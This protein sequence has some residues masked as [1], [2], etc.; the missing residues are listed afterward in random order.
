MAAGNA[1]WGIEVGSGAVKAIKL[2]ATPT[3]AQ[4]AEY[5]LIQHPRVLSEPEIDPD[6]AK[7]V[8]LGRLVN[9]FD[10]SG[11]S[12][13]VSIP[14]HSSF[15]RFAKLPPVEPKKLGG[16][17]RYEA[18]QQI[19]FS[20]DEVE[21]DYQT[22]ASPD[23][24]EVEAGI[25]AVTRARIMQDLALLK[26]V[27]LTPDV[28]TLSPVAVY[29][30]LAWDL[31][32]T[33]QTPGT[34]ILDIGTTATDLIVA[35]AGR[36]WVRTFPMGGHEF[37]NALVEAFKLSYQKADKLK[38]E[39]EESKHAR[40]VFGALRPVFTDLAQD[41]Q[42]SIGY[43]QSLH[44]DAD[45]QRLIGLG[46]TFELPG[47]RKFLKQ[48]LGMNVYR[49]ERYKRIGIEGPRAAEFEPLALNLTTAYGLALQGLGLAT[50]EANLMPTGVIREALWK[51]KGKWFLTAA[52]L[53]LAAGGAM[54]IR[55]FLDS[56]AVN[57]VVPDISIDQA[58]RL[59]AD[60]SNEASQA[61]VT[62]PARG[63]FAAA[64][65]IGVLQGREIFPY[66]AA[67]VG[68]LVATGGSGPDRTFSLASMQ[69]EY[70]F[71][72][73][74]TFAEPTMPSRR[75]REE[76]EP[77][78]TDEEMQGGRGAI[79]A[80]PPADPR[81]R[82]GRDEGYAP[83]PGM[84]TGDGAPPP[85]GEPRILVTLELETT[86]PRDQ[87]L[88]QLPDTIGRWLRENAD[89][90][91]APYTVRPAQAG[92]DPWSIEMVGGPQPGAAPGRLPPREVAGSG[93]TGGRVAGGPRDPRGREGEDRG[94]ITTE[95]LIRQGILDP[96]N[97]VGGGGTA[98]A[99]EEAS[100][101]HAAGLSL[102]AIA[103]LAAPAEADPKPVTRVI[104]TFEAVLREHTKPGAPV[105]LD[106]GAA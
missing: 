81:S 40:H 32:F 90:P 61:G 35:E 99:R 1:C 95:D 33:E 60:F 26:E 41:V 103:P 105:R 100:R 47:L 84:G 101:Q 28:V 87:L 69:S 75:E 20:L 73:S 5:A 37:T 34:V 14:G 98:P 93:R 94:F 88:V 57:A 38:R 102:D 44:R 91:G 54:F 50:L 49:L 22:F 45:L 11:A 82:G 80:R 97:I 53:G 21:W 78:V 46:S 66:L 39:A 9:E 18:A 12:I 63:N 71:A 17:V 2:E 58:T 89:R 104:V 16:I 74:A 24:P 77:E 15:A 52:G 19:P 79:R 29:N 59:A 10:L 83:P 30:A 3:G 92:V 67:D 23:Q 56:A 86:A 65:V 13:A 6:D 96:G 4:V 42:R 7:R 68:E 25:F 106:G 76:I 64:Q 70:L 85:E 72:K 48:Q 51:K 36:V 55:P 62:E 8:A 27:G 43:Y 31:E